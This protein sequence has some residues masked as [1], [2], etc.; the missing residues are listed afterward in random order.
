MGIGEE[1]VSLQA[2]G[3]SPRYHP[4][5]RPNI[6]IRPRT[7]IVYK[8]LIEKGA[9]PCV[10][11]MFARRFSDPN[12][13]T[14]S[15]RSSL[16]MLANVE[17][18]KDA[19]A[20]ASM[21]SDIIL[22][23]GRI[24]FCTDYDSDGCSSAA[25]IMRFAR[26]GGFD[27][28]IRIFT[29]NRFAD[30]YGINPNIVEDAAAW[31][32]DAIVTADNGIA[33]FPAAERARELEIPLIVT[34]HH[35]PPEELPPATLIVNPMRKDCGYQNRVIC[36]ATVIFLVLSLVKKKLVAAGYEQAGRI[37]MRRMLQIVGAATVADCVPMVGVNRA[38]VRVGL[39]MLRKDPYPGYKAFIE[40]TGIDPAQ[41]DEESIG[42]KIGP[43]INASS[44]LGDAAPSI[45]FL[46]EDNPDKAKQH[47]LA[48]S[49][50]NEQRKEVQADVLTKAEKA[51]ESFIE[52]YPD[53]PILF[54]GDA[55]WHQGVVGIIAGRIAEK[56]R[57]PAFVFGGDT[58][59]PNILKGSGRSG[60]ANLHL[61]DFLDRL[62]ER[63]PDAIL[64]YGGHAKAAGLT[65]RKDALPFIV[66]EAVS[67][68]LTEDIGSAPYPVDV[69]VHG[70]LSA[71]Q[72]EF[73]FG[74]LKCAP[75][76]PGFETPRIALTTTVT[77]DRF[78]GTGSVRFRISG[79]DAI[80]F[81]YA[82]LVRDIAGATR[83]F[84]LRP[85]FNYFRG[86]I[87]RQ[88]YVEAIL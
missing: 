78:V 13:A 30:G 32:A 28:L 82:E 22:N 7:T 20:A 3:E 76:G 44:R 51:A 39:E 25:V 8:A 79:L 74:W 9:E 72:V 66:G 35:L 68:C 29:P 80:A 41:V 2:G 1:A 23:E 10:A 75:F 18:M 38:I 17:Q 27:D 11:D 54:L 14:E 67:L 50:L 33:A 46:C 83:T 43:A 81:G 61:K 59:D 73:V 84:I 70:T 34:D 24:A 45:D 69:H 42:Y 36:G 4:A 57:R 21:I 77:P 16:G 60:D 26:E 47:A 19:D 6:S 64:G 65:I 55:D 12:A 37:D 86:T 15:F 85:S 49:R 88:F 58:N 40:A 48:L 52:H 71:E 56:M 53:C 63:A 5:S 31:G 62:A 87:K